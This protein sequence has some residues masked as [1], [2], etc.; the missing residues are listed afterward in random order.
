MSERRVFDT[1]FLALL[2]T[3]LMVIALALHE[4]WDPLE[5]MWVY[6]CQSV[7]IGF[8]NVLRILLL[9]EEGLQPGAKVVAAWFFCLHYGGFHAG[10]LVFLLSDTPSA[11]ISVPA[12]ALSALIFLANHCYSFY[13]Y[14]RQTE[15]KHD[16][17]R[18]L[19]FPYARILPMHLTIIFGGFFVGLTAVSATLILFMLLKTAADLAMHVVEHG[20]GKVKI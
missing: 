11:V 18:L 16:L 10:Y 14:R 17:A 5:A 15:P 4:R 6:W 12:I 19:F 1:S 13:H 7:I 20:E 8:F 9:K 2:L 3:N